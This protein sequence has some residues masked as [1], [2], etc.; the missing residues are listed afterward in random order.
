MLPSPTSPTKELT[1]FGAQ[2]DVISRVL[3]TFTKT[4]VHTRSHSQALTFGLIFQGPQ[5]NWLQE[6]LWSALGVTLLG[7]DLSVPSSAIPPSAGHQRPS[8]KCKRMLGPAAVLWAFPGVLE[9]G[10][11]PNEELHF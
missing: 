8:Q 6:L 1:G 4:V 2:H 7:T 5:F 3:T 9:A 10:K 11:E